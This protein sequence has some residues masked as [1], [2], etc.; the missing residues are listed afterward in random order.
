MIKNIFSK[1]IILAIV[2]CAFAPHFLYAQE[3]VNDYQATLR[4]KVLEV[5]GERTKEIPWTNT[6]VDEQT[7]KVEILNGDQ[8]GKIVTIE[9][10]YIQLKKGQKFYINHL[11]DV[12]GTERFV[13]LNVD[14]RGGIVIVIALFVF[15]V[16][17]LGRWQ[18]LRSL[19]A[20]VGSFLAIFYI[21][22]PGLLAGWN[23][24]L[25][26]SLVAA[27]VLFLQYFLPTVLIE[28]QRLRM[29]VL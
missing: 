8:K 24:F 5:L 13:V 15:S 21:L 25:A 26:S 6:S 9:N 1:I 22:I 2:A 12:D 29:A 3:V 20:L 14:R 7:I 23:P 28:N 11:V 17:A 19:V 10:D 18:G 27:G 16:I 4:A